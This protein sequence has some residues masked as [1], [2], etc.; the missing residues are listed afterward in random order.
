M[1]SDL[2][3]EELSYLATTFAVTISEGLDNESLKVMCSFF[4]DVIGTLNLIINQRHLKH[5][6]HHDKD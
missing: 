6:R 2:T 4:A 1:L 3:P 5:E